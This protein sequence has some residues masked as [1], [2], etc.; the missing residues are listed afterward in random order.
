[1][2]L[3]YNPPEEFK[4]TYT[5]TGTGT[6]TLTQEQRKARR[7]SVLVE[8]IKLEPKIEYFNY[9]LP[10]PEAFWGYLQLVQR[11]YIEKTH[12]LQYRREVIVSR[13]DYPQEWYRQIMCYVSQTQFLAHNRLL[14][15]MLRAGFTPAEVNQFAVAWVQET[16]FDTVLPILPT[17]AIWY[18]VEP[19]FAAQITVIW[20]DSAQYCGGDQ[21]FKFLPPPRG[22]KADEQRPND[23]GGGQQPVSPPPA[24]RASDPLSDSPAPPPE[25]PGGPPSP[26]PGPAFSRTKVTL[27]FPE[28]FDNTATP[29]TRGLTATKTTIINGVHPA[30]DFAIR[31][32]PT[33]GL[34]PARCPETKG[35]LSVV[36]T[37]KGADLPNMDGGPV[38]FGVYPTIKVEYL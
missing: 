1:M 3:T 36:V 8:K 13:D 18:E 29:C 25:A 35:Y 22:T 16:R 5:C 11:D 4:E 34:P 23:G 12:Q 7:I 37:F 19:G 14:D 17:T 15:L 32:R 33:D 26:T 21:T 30:S 24:D 27:N 6:I 20:Q 2:S 38:E 9:R 10:E 28:F 31:N